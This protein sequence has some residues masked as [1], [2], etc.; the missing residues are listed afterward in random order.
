MPMSAV[1]VWVG[2]RLWVLPMLC[3]VG[4]AALGLGLSALGLERFSRRS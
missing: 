3:A 1:R 4:A 2:E